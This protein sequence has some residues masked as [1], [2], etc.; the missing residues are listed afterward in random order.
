MNFHFNQM[1]KLILLVPLVYSCKS[2]PQK[3][4]HWSS[5]KEGITI[6]RQE[7]I[8]RRAK[9]KRKK[10]ILNALMEEATSD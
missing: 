9:Q 10:L 6:G 3:P 5:P 7:R 4:E 1:Q 2:L 8:E